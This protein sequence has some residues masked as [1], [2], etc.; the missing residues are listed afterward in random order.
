[1]AAAAAGG[2]LTVAALA[3]IIAA[4]AAVNR[5][6][7]KNMKTLRSTADVLAYFK[8][9]FLDSVIF[10]YD[11]I[12]DLEIERQSFSILGVSKNPFGVS[13]SGSAS[14]FGTY[15]PDVTALWMEPRENKGE[16]LHAVLSSLT[17]KARYR[18]GS[19]WT[20]DWKNQWDHLEKK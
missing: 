6:S 10:P 12:C 19:G 15:T 13:V 5:E 14:V 8:K 17:S 18:A 11:G 7:L 3:P 2:L 1:M 16:Q 9:T 4:T 20:F